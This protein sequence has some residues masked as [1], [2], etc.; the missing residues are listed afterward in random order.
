MFA[1][2]FLPPQRE[3]RTAVVVVL[4]H[5]IAMDK[6][7]RKLTSGC[8]HM[9]APMGVAVY[10]VECLAGCYILALYQSS[11]SAGCGLG[12]RRSCTTAARQPPVFCRIVAGVLVCSFL[13]SAWYTYLQVRLTI[14]DGSVRAVW[15]YSNRS[16]YSRVVTF[17]CERPTSIIKQYQ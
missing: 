10:S 6:G 15:A 4:V 8:K 3:E 13:R 17:S 11:T 7:Q 14:L 1:V 5:R 16:L 2:C 12:R 9:H